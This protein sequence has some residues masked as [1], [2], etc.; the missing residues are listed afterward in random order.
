MLNGLPYHNTMNRVRLLLATALLMMFSMT[1]N[2]Q[3]RG[4]LNAQ[5]RNKEVNLDEGEIVSNILKV[6]NP[7][8]RLRTFNVATTEP[9][10]WKRLSPRDQSYKLAP[11]DSA[12]IPIRLIPPK[13]AAGAALSIRLHRPPHA[14]PL[15]LA[16]QDGNDLSGGHRQRGTLERQR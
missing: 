13:E 15:D 10:G 11:G 8:D 16:R 14:A 1:A 2:A 6:Y 4:I 9:A 7:G 12:F 3:Q 5:V